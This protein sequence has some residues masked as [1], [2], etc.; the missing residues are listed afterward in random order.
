MDVS[1]KAGSPVARGRLRRI[2]R[3]FFMM[4]PISESREQE[5]DPQ[6]VSSEAAEAA[7]ADAFDCVTVRTPWALVRLHI[8]G[9]D[10]AADA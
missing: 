6:I 9:I 7:R 3:P 8:A 5:E 4:T 10:E 1:Q 2:I